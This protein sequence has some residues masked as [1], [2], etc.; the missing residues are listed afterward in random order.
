MDAAAF[1]VIGQLGFIPQRE[2][3]IA[4]GVTAK[5]NLNELYE[6][7][8]Y[9]RDYAIIKNSDA[10]Y[11]QDV[12]TGYTKFFLTNPTVSEIKNAC[13]DKKIKYNMNRRINDIQLYL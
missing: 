4:C 2:E 6:K 8:P 7:F 9:L 13:L 10:H 12:G 3:I 5:C 1:S 11:P